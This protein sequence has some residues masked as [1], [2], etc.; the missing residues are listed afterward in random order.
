MKIPYNK[1]VSIFQILLEHTA[2][3]FIAIE[4]ANEASRIAMIGDVGRVFGKNIS[5]DLIDGIIA[6]F[7]KRR[8]HFFQNE[9]VFRLLIGDDGECGGL[10]LDVHRH[11]HLPFQK[12]HFLH[13]IV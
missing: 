13:I 4:L 6:L 2:E 11:F 10:T 1:N 3:Q 12:I 9:L 5:D 7:E 8:I